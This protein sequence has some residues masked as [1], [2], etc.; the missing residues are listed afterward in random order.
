MKNKLLIT[1]FVALT[2]IGLQAADFTSGKLKFNIIPDSPNEVE[3]V[4]NEDSTVVYGDLVIPATVLQKQG[5]K[6]PKT[7][8]VTAIAPDAFRGKAITSITLPDWVQEIP[9]S[10]F[11]DCIAL[12]RVAF[13][14]SVTHIG[15]SAFENCSMLREI[16]VP[17]EITTIEDRTFFRCKALKTLP[18]HDNIRV[19]G[20][21]AFA[22][23]TDL[24]TLLLDAIE[25][26]GAG[27]FH[28]C[29]D[30]KMLRLGENVKSIGSEA[31]GGCTNIESV[32]WN[33]KKCT[34]PNPFK[35][36]KVA[37]VTA[38]RMG[39]KVSVLPA[40]LCAGMSSLTTIALPPTVRVIG[41]GAF[42]GCSKLQTINL[43]E[44]L[45]RI[46]K[47]LFSGDRSLTVIVIPDRVKAIEQE[48]FMG[49]SGL[50]SLTMGDGVTRIEKYAFSG[51]SS[52]TELIIGD[53]VRYIAEG[54]FASCKSLTAVTFGS[55]VDSI[56]PNAFRNTNNITAID[57]RP[58]N[59][60]A[61]NPFRGINVSKVTALAIHDEVESLPPYFCAGMN[62]LESVNVPN[63]VV[64]IEENAFAGCAGLKRVVLGRGIRRIGGGG[65]LL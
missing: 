58:A 52:L 24:D 21:L 49:C 18:V 7:F 37:G 46:E 44:G 38:F 53:S 60:P 34:A 33:V 35:G 26:I 15:K 65:L 43:P 27:A 64:S 41:E 40:R 31:F 20:E 13:S 29:T 55:S 17:E 39:N 62:S 12:E 56:A 14:D 16:T 22:E 1:L 47:S 11:L 9:D 8:K 54:A 50:Q 48:A 57:W 51:A 45:A 3:L 28:D 42:Q 59:Y 10:M 32:D 5:K 6:K 23:C 25:T 61:G 36:A 19:V 30:L 2:S 63:N 4:R